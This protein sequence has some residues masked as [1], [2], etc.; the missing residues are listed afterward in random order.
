MST[1]TVDRSDPGFPRGNT[2][3][4][5]WAEYF[6]ELFGD[7]RDEIDTGLMIGWFANAIETG[8]MEGQR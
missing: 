3:A 4:L 6:M 8:R 7:R 5:V 1:Q 2:D